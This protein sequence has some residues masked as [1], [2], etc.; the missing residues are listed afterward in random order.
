MANGGTTARIVS[1]DVNRHKAYWS[2]MGVEGSGYHREKRKKLHEEIQK[3]I[4]IHGLDEVTT[5]IRTLYEENR[6]KPT[7]PEL[8]RI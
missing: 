6:K 8:I 5:A 3:L 7:G 1:D 2:Q 4:D